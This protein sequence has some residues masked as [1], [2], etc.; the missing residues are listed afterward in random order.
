MPDEHHRWRSAFIEL[1]D[2]LHRHLGVTMPAIPD[3]ADQSL[4]FEI[5]WG[6]VVFRLDHGD[7]DDADGRMRVQC[8][9]GRVPEDDADRILGQALVANSVLARLQ[10]GMFALDSSDRSL[11]FSFVQPLAATHA[12][13]LAAALQRVAEAAIT[14]RQRNHFASH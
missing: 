10:S 13:E 9:F 3:A 6:G 2:D 8:G 7:P 12:A 1:A 11:K 4:A 14:W 5:S